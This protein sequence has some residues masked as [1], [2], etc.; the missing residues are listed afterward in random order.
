VR[1]QTP[2]E[3]LNKNLVNENIKTEVQHETNQNMAEIQNEKNTTEQ[4]GSQLATKE[5]TEIHKKRSG[6]SGKNFFTGVN[7]KDD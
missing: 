5:K 7:T 3:L 1:E 2:K 4:Q 6:V